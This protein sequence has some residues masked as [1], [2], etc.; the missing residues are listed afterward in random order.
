[1]I[2]RGKLAG[3]LDEAGDDPASAVETLRAHNIRWACLRQLWSGNVVDVTDQAIAKVKS[4]LDHGG[5]R[6]IMLSTEI[7]AVIPDTLASVPRDRLDRALHLANYFGATFVRFK[8]GKAGPG[9]VQVEHIES[10]MNDIQ[11]RALRANIVPLLELAWDQTL[12]EPADAARW[13][14]AYP[15]WKLLYDPTQVIL[16]RKLDPFVKYW[17]LLKTKIGAID[18]H[19]VKTGHNFRPVGQGDSC[20]DRTLKDASES[21]YNGWY[22]V[23]PGLGRRYGTALTRRDTFGLAVQALDILEET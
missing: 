20:W 11:N 5:V 1:M 10:W 17:T 19:D 23:E 15:R 7:G 13:L 12:S 6:T 16:H 4:I 8:V 2:D 21:K 9:P 22:F 14:A 18:L 3:Y